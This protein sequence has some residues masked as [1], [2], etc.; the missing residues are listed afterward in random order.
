MHKGK[1][2]NVLTQRLSYAL[3]SLRLILLTQSVYVHGSSEGERELLF[4]GQMRDIEECT[5]TPPFL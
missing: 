1:L 5:Y 4:L 2:S 3:F